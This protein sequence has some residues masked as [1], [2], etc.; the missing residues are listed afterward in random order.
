MLADRRYR[1]ELMCIGTYGSV[2]HMKP[3]P[4]QTVLRV[5][6]QETLLHVVPLNGQKPVRTFKAPT[7]FTFHYMNAFESGE[8]LLIS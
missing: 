4:Q 2:R 8:R 5:A 7:Y 1:L 6:L 3:H